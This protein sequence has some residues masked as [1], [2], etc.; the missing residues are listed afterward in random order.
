MKTTIDIPDGTMEEAMKF[1]GAKTK[2]SD[3]AGLILDGSDDIYV[4][5]ADPNTVGDEI[6]V[7]AAGAN[8]DAA[9]I[10]IIAG[11]KTELNEPSQLALDA[12]GNIYAANYTS[13]SSIS[14]VTAYS[15]G[16]KGNVKPA[17]T[18]KGKHS[19]L[20]GPDG[21]AMDADGNVY[22]ASYNDSLITVYGSGMFGNVKP[23]RTL[24]GG[25]FH[26]GGITIR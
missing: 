3:P 5:D 17:E 1:T 4:P 23:I 8:G 10:E 19:K 6:T 2:L 20:D 25:I 12:A 16:A 22:V 14:I 13:S 18:I 9:P 7:Y 26:P 24:T 21:V 15:N 11:D